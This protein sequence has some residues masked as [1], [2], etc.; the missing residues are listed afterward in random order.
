MPF[1]TELKRRKVLRAGGAYLV[2]VWVLIQVVDVVGPGL[3]AP[4]WILTVVIV[5]SVIGL[6]IVLVL[7]WAY[8][9]K[10]T[11]L[12]R[13]EPEPASAV[14]AKP[15]GAARWA[16]LS[17]FM[18]LL[19]AVA[20]LLTDK[21]L[22]S[23]GDIVTLPDGRRSIAVL[24]FENLSS[25][26][27]QQY[28]ADGIAE[29]ILNAL[30]TVQE[31][32]VTSRTSSFALRDS[33]LSTREIARQLDADYIVEGSVRRSGDTARIT[34]QLIQARSDGHLLSENYDV[35]LGV[36]E[37]LDVQED[38]ARRISDRLQVRV[39]PGDELRD[40]PPA[41]L[42]ALEHYLDGK[43]YLRV[44]ETLSGGPDQIYRTAIERF[45]ASIAAD[46]NWAPSRQALGATFHM[47]LKRDN[48]EDV[49]QQSYEQIQQALR[50]DADYQPAWVSLGYL[51]L[52]K[53]KFDAALD[54][55]DKV[56]VPTRNANWGKAILMVALSQYDR[57]KDHYRAAWSLDPLSN[58]IRV[59]YAVT[60]VCAS[61]YGEAIEFI[62]ETRADLRAT[63]YPT[64]WLLPELAY[65]HAK[66]GNRET[67]GQIVDK[68]LV[69]EEFRLP[70]APALAL[71]GRRE[72]ALSI[73][74]DTDKSDNFFPG[75]YPGAAAIL[76]DRER[77]IGY[78]ENT[79]RESPGLLATSQ[80][81]CYEEV[82]KLAS[83]PRYTRVL[84]N[85]GIPEEYRGTD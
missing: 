69:E 42:T 84:A 30:A 76:G 16:E 49:W 82:R 6:P 56:D 5:C 46:P 25:D 81:H 75:Y 29:E 71:L 72:E 3:G 17:L 68:W 83:D 35:N 38:V 62:E 31:L 52:R 44:I 77:A 18:A 50:I 48:F 36:S 4:D 33:D 24:P 60:L 28:F 2:A 78:L 47:W 14:A 54:A 26:A 64:D 73:L 61:A 15:I 13:S 32:R 9:L 74:A 22:L 27:E 58:N 19:V 1:L 40:N 12:T 20:Y 57:A 53:Q 59:Q 23:A 43:S 34:V 41:N 8:D 21:L 39:L 51:Q 45:E 55:Y 66:I 65:A 80:F 37:L 7:A 70:I 79:L 63:D 10:T 11:G 67:A 85:L